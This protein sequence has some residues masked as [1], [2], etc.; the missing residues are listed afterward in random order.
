MAGAKTIYLYGDPEAEHLRVEVRGKEV[1]LISHECVVQ[2]I[3]NIWR[4][5][6]LVSMPLEKWML[7]ARLIDPSQFVG[8]APDDPK[9]AVSEGPS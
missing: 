2:K 6:Y 1:L 5:R 8:E 4:D 7:V 3:T 9:K